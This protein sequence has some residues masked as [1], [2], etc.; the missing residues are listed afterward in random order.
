[1]GVYIS[2]ENIILFVT[3]ICSSFV[4]EDSTAPTLSQEAFGASWKVHSCL[5]CRKSSWAFPF[6]HE[7][8]QYLSSMSRTFL[9]KHGMLLFSHFQSFLWQ[10]I[11]LPKDTYLLLSPESSRGDNC[12]QSTGTHGSNVTCYVKAQIR[13]F[14]LTVAK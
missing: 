10:V 8:I 9:K 1:M 11:Y 14:S 12:P 7:Q 5:A 6:S 4:Y 2:S 13:T 3:N